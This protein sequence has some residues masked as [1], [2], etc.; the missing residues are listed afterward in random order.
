M[1]LPG[2]S[3]REKR[4]WYH[5]V[6]QEP[7][8][9]NAQQPK[10]R[11]LPAL[12]SVAVE[13]LKLESLQRICSTVEPL[14]RRI[15]REELEQAFTKLGHAQ[16]IERPPLAKLEGPEETK[17]HLCFR[18]KLPPQL[19]TGAKVE[20][21][22]GA[23]IHVLLL[24]ANTG[25]VVVGRS[26]SSVKLN[27]VVLEGDFND[28]EDDSWT[29][30]R[31][32][33]FEVKEREG[34]RPLLA[35]DLEVSLTEG[36]GT[37]GDLTFTDNSSWTRSRKFRLGVKVAPG[38][39]DEIRIREA[40]TDAFTVKDHRGELY[41]KHYPPALHDEVWRLDRI[42]KEGAL[43]NKLLCA[44]IFTVKDF[45]RLL[46]R[47]HK[48]LRKVLGSGMSQRMWEN[49]VD[50]AKT[51]VL[52]DQQYVYYTDEVR[53][54]GIVLNDICEI[55]G[56][57]TDGQFMSSELLSQYQKVSANSLVARAYK[58]WNQVQ[59]YEGETL[60]KSM[61][62]RGRQ[63]CNVEPTA[64]RETIAELLTQTNHGVITE[65]TNRCLETSESLSHRNQLIEI[66]SDHS[67]GLALATSQTTTIRQI[68]LK[69]CDPSRLVSSDW[70]RHR[71]GRRFEQ[72]F[73]GQ[74]ISSRSTGMSGNEN[75]QWLLGNFDGSSSH[76]DETFYSHS[77]NYRSEYKYVETEQARSQISGKAVAGWLKLRA[78]LKWGIFTRK[79]TAERRA[80]LVELE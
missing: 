24:H 16:Q 9:E 25:H 54:N 68:A 58:N 2:A 49:T 57:I 8:G 10:K 29:K 37:L 1:E 11:K 15:V 76:T 72:F 28:E 44:G 21:E 18:S 48:K 60:S 5:Q 7:E 74:G 45:L 33:S 62:G 19:F 64:D 67:L 31:F 20:G 70:S 42:A 3:R 80:Q 17:I 59:K 66:P 75:M 13:A 65:F 30:E 69:P 40:K 55:R 61:N 79:R 35:G 14:L 34:K 36:V 46:V 63:V 26:E 52:N 47:D 78:A 32:E 27:V 22:Q 53:M 71:E 73:S 50:H 56:L 23:A 51:C 6:E 38:I 4:G 39:C 43:H 41:K 77:M 12:A